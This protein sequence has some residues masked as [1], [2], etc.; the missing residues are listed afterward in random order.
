MVSAFWTK[1]IM[2]M[3]ILHFLGGIVYLVYKLSPR[4]GDKEGKENK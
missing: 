3:V 4:K 2:L 1:F